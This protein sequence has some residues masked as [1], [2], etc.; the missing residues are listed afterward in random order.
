MSVGAVPRSP[1]FAT[2]TLNHT[3]PGSH[4]AKGLHAH[5]R[6]TLLGYTNADVRDSF[7]QWQRQGKGAQDAPS[8]CLPLCRL[9]GQGPFLR[10]G[11]GD[12]HDV[13]AH[14]EEDAHGG[15]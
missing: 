3:F 1:A 11:N 12:P 9:P 7:W 4:S 2:R 15:P 8:L 6:K 14:D 5:A 10:Q 13:D